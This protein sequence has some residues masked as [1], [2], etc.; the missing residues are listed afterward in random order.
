MLT[1]KQK[2][3]YD[4]ISAA[5]L[6][7]GG[8]VFSSFMVFKEYIKDL[9]GKHSLLLLDLK[10]LIFLMSHLAELVFVVGR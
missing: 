6:C 10:D 4:E 8:G 7:N 9:C 3:I 2:G 1:T 5:V